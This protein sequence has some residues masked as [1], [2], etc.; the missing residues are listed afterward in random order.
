LR[1]EVFDFQP[2]VVEIAFFQRDV[3]RG[4]DRI[5]AALA[6]DDLAQPGLGLRRADAK[7]VGTGDGAGGK[8]QRATAGGKRLRVSHH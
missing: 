8:Q 7:L 4:E 6:I 2:G 1:V 3:A 5:D